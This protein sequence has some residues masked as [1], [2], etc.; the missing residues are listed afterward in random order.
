[1]DGPICFEDAK[2]NRLCRI[3]EAK[4]KAGFISENDIKI[5]KELVKLA[6]KSFL[7]LDFLNSF[8]LNG[9]L[10]I[11][12]KGS[13]GALIGKGGKNIKDM[14]QK[15]GKKIRIVEKTSDAKETAQ[16]L[17]GYLKI[18]AVNKVFR[19]DSEELKIIL[20]KQD[21]KKLRQ[22]EETE[23]ILTK[24]LGAKTTIEFA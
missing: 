9:M 8:E 15:L 17:L 6:E 23:K 1:M 5:W 22:K 4:L 3:C 19:P 18:V 14:E 12:C 24:L 21:E 7:D 13:I 11:V 10:V 16:A 20:S 2:T